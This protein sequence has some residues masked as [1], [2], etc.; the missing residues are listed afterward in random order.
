MFLNDGELE[1]S[2]DNIKTFQIFYNYKFVNEGSIFFSSPIT[3]KKTSTFR[4]MSFSSFA[5]L[6]MY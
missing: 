4:L 6:R 1:T 5:I 3:F 2:V